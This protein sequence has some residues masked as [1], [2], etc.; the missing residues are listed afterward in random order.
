MSWRRVRP[1]PNIPVNRTP[2]A[3]RWTEPAFQNKTY[4][5]QTD[6]DSS[7]DLKG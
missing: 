1:V 3:R 5:I 6:L 4:E 2:V 7:V